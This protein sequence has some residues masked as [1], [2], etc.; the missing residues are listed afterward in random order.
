MSPRVYKAVSGHPFAPVCYWSRIVYCLDSTLLNTQKLL[1]IW[2]HTVILFTAGWTMCYVFLPAQLNCP[3]GRYSCNGMYFQLCTH[4]K[5]MSH[6]E[7]FG[8]APVPSWW[9]N[10]TWQLW[11]GATDPDIL[12]GNS[13]C[14]LDQWK[15]FL[16][17][18]VKTL[19][20]FPFQ[21]LLN[22]L[23]L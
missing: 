2:P 8:R 21:T 20:F 9:F 17:S 11:L 13:T 23:F 4:W 6:L 22:F 3:S 14:V 1:P 18:A 5:K 16:K 15:L 10:S 19:F 12:G 7:K